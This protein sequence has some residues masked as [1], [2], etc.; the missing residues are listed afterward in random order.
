MDNK[1]MDS[2]AENCG[3]FATLNRKFGEVLNKFDLKNLSKHEINHIKQILVKY[4]LHP[5]ATIFVAKNFPQ[6]LPDLLTKAINIEEVQ[7][8]NE[9]HIRNC[10]ILSKLLDVHPDV[11]SFVIK[12]FEKNPSPFISL[13]NTQQP[14]KQ[15]TN[16][17][18]IVLNDKEIICMVYSFLKKMPDYFKRKWCWSEFIEK[19]ENNVDETVKWI[20]CNCLA[21]ITNMTEITL[22]K[23]IL[24]KLTETQANQCSIKYLTN[25]SL[26]KDITSITFN[27]F[28]DFITPKVTSLTNINGI[29]LPVIGEPIESVQKIVEVDS[30]NNNLKKIALGIVSNKRINLIGPVGSGKTALIEYLASKTG[31][32]LGESFIKIQL[33]DQSDSKML[34]GT[35]R[36]TDIPGE[37]I[38]QPGVLTQAVMDGSWLLLEDIDSASIDIASLLSGLLENGYL[39]VPG[40]RD[41]VPIKQ[42]FQLFVTQRLL[43]SVS[44]YQRIT[45]PSTVLLEKHLLNINIQPLSLEELEYIIK[46][47]HPTLKTISTRII[48]IFKYLNDNVNLNSTDRN[49]RC[50]TTR[51][52]FKWCSRAVVNFDV[53]SPTSGLKLL[54]DALDVFCY[55]YS[56]IDD[57]NKL[58]QSICSELGI[59]TEKVN[60]F[61]NQYK[62]NLNVSTKS[63]NCGRAKLKV[64]N[65]LTERKVN[66]CFTR[67]ASCLL[68]RIMCCISANE[69][70]LLVGETGTGKTSTVQY[71][72]RMLGQKLIVINMNQQ[73]DSSD[74]FGGFK[75][76]EIKFIIGPVKSEFENLFHS[77]YNANENE[78][79]LGHINHCFSKERYNDLVVLMKTCCKSALKK[80]ENGEQINTGAKRK[81]TKKNKK[82]N[83]NDDIKIKWDNFMKKIEKLEQQLKHKNALAFTFVEGSLVKAIENGYWVLLDEINLASVETLDCLSGLLE[84]KHSS[85]SLLERGDKKP[86]KRHDNFTLFA[87]MN[88]S[89]DV[90]KKNLPAGL[91]NRFTELFVDELT[92][93]KDLLMLVN[94]YLETLSTSTKTENIVKF[95]SKVRKEAQ[96]ILCDG[97]GHKP[98]FSLR[99]LCRA[100]MIGSKNPC[101]TVLRSLYEAFC[102]SFLTQLDLSSYKIVERMISKYIV[103]SENQLKSVIKQPIPKPISQRETYNFLQFEGYWISQGDLE[104]EVP[105][106]YILTPSVRKNLKD[107][108]RI[109]S[110]G[111]LPILLQGDTSVGKTSLIGYLAKSSGNKC[112]RINNHEHTDLQEYIGSYVADVSGKLV[113]REGVLVE[114][115]RNGHW[116]ILDELNLAPSDVLEALNRVLDDNRE[117]FIPET[118]QVVKAHHKFMLFATQNPPGTY[119]GRKMLSRAFRNRFVE[120]HF[121]EIPAV[122]LETILQQRCSLAPSYAKK[123]INVMKDLQTRRRGSAAFAGKYG[124]I[125]LRDLFRWGERYRLAEK[126]DKLYDWDQHLADEG[127]LVLAG[128]VRK[129]EE[130]LEIIAVLKKYLKRDVIPNNLFTLSDK[131]STVTKEILKKLYE[132]NEKYNNIVWTYNMRQMAVLVSKALQFYEPVL[133]VGETGCGKT[134]ICDVI[135]R[136]NN[137]KLMTI[138][139]HMHTESSDFIGGLRPVR[140]H[141]DDVNK[142]FEWIDGPL[143][144]AMK[145]GCLF[146]T[147]EISLADDSVLERLNSLLEPE[148]SLLL[149]EKGIDINNQANSELIIAH[150]DFHFIGTMNPGGDYGKKELSP[151]L[152]NR[153]TEIWS[154]PCSNRQDFINIINHNVKTNVLETYNIGFGELIMDFIDWFQKEDIGK[155][156][157]LTIRDV[158]TWV[159]FINACSNKISIKDLYLNGAYITMLDS[160]GSGVLNIENKDI[161]ANIKSKS[162]Q[163]LLNTLKKYNI[164]PDL[165][166]NVNINDDDQF[167]IG[168][169]SIQIGFAE[170]PETYFS[171]QAPTTFYNALRVVRG[172]QLNKPIL[173]EGSPGVG[174]TSLV[175]ALA[176]ATQNKLYRVNLSDQTDISD[177]FGADLPV[178]G[179]KSGQFSWRDGP[180]LQALKKGHWVLLDELNLASQSVLEGLNACLDHR[181]EIFIPELGKTFVVKEGT[182]FFG[183][184]NPIRQ[185]GSRRGLPKSFLNRFTQVYVESLT[186]NDYQ[187]ILKS[188][189]P[190]IEEILIETMVRFN[191]ELAKVLNRHLF[192]HLGGPWEYNLRDLTRWCEI[193]NN[194]FKETG[195][196]EPEKFINLIY[197]NRLRK[198]EDRNLMRELFQSFFKTNPNLEHGIVYVTFDKI[199]IGD[200]WMNREIF[201]FNLSEKDSNLLVLR[202]QMKNLRDLCYCV[203][204]NWLAILVGG[205]GSGKSSLVRTLAGLAGKTLLTLPVTSAM[206]TSDLLGGFEQTDYTRH[207]E[208]LFKQTESLLNTTIHS[209]LLSHEGF[210]S[211]K[212]LKAL[213]KCREIPGLAVEKHTMAEETKLFIKKIEYLMALWKEIENNRLPEKGEEK[214]R[215]LRKK[216]NQLLSCVN[217]EGGLNAGGKFEWVDSV[218]IKSLINGYWLLIDNVNLCSPAVLDR[219]NGLLEPNGVLTISERGIDPEGKMIEIKPHKDFRLFFTMNPKNGE[220]SRAMRNRGIELFLLNHDYIESQ[221]TLDIKSLIFSNGIENNFVINTLIEMHKY[222]SDLIVGEKPTTIDLLQSAFLISQQINRGINVNE[223]VTC[224]IMDIYYKMRS[225]YEFNINDAGN[226]IKIRINEIMLGY[227]K[228]DEFFNENCTLKI[229]DIN[230]NSNVAKIKQ[231]I[232]CFGNYLERNDKRFFV[233]NCYYLNHFYSMSTFNDLELRH[234][235]VKNCFKNNF[236]DI[237]YE[238]LK[239]MAN[240]LP[241]DDSW[242]SFKDHNNFYLMLYYLTSK[243]IVEQPPRKDLKVTLKFIQ[244]NKRKFSI[245]DTDNII[246]KKIVILLNEFDSFVLN[247]LKKNLIKIPNDNFMEFLSGVEWRKYIYPEILK[248]LTYNNE[249]D[250]NNFILLY[251]H[252]KWFAKY[253]VSKITEILP[254]E[255]SDELLT[256]VEKINSLLPNHFSNL[257]KIGKRYK[258]LIPA[259][260]PIINEKHLEIVLNFDQIDDIFNFYKTSNDKIKI[261]DYKLTS[262]NITEEPEELKYLKEK[263]KEIVLATDKSVYKKFDI[264]FLV[265]LDYFGLLNVYRRRNDYYQLENIDLITIPFNLRGVLKRYQESNDEKLLFEINSSITYYLLN[266]ICRNKLNENDNEINKQLSLYS[267][268][269]SSLLTKFLINE[270]SSIQVKLEEYKDSYNLYNKFMVILWS[271]FGDLSAKT[272]DFIVSDQKYILNSFESFLKD[273]SKSLRISFNQNDYKEMIDFCIN[274]ISTSYHKTDDELKILIQLLQCSLKSVI[275]L[276]DSFDATDKLGHLSDSFIY[277]NYL[278]ALLNSKLPPI[279]S[280]LKREIKRKYLLNEIEN[281]ECLE[282]SYKCQGEIYTNDEYPIIECFKKKQEDLKRKQVELEEYLAVRPSNLNYRSIFQVVQ[283]AFSTILSSKN[284]LEYCEKLN[285]SIKALRKSLETGEYLN[286]LEKGLVTTGVSSN[287]ERFCKVLGKNRATYPDV[288]EPLYS[289][290]LELLYGIKLKEDL[291]KKLYMKCSHQRKGLNLEKSLQNLV[292]FPI[293]NDE[294]TNF[295]QLTNLYLNENLLNFCSEKLFKYLKCGILEIYNYAIISSKFKVKNDNLAIYFEKLIKQFIGVWNKH[296]EMIE[297]ERNESQTLYKFKS[298]E[299]KTEEEIIQEEFDELFPSYHDDDFKEFQ[300]HSLDHIHKEKEVTIKEDVIKLDD[301]KYVYEL[302]KNFFDILTKTNWIESNNPEDNFDHVTPLIEKY[303][304]F[305]VLLDNCVNS[306]DY[307]LDQKLLGSLTVLINYAKNFGNSHHNKKNYNFYHDSNIEE[308]KKSLHI[309]K[310]LQIEINK[311]LNEWPEH[312]TLQKLNTIINRIYNFDV[313][314]SISRFLTGFEILLTECNEWEQNAHSGVSLQSSIT[315]VTDQII[316]WRK[317]ELNMWKNSLNIVYEKL[318]L[319]IGKWWCFIYNIIDQ[320]ETNNISEIEFIDAI[321]KF[322]T[323]SNIAE[324]QNRLGL[325]KSFN[326][327][328]VVIKKSRILQNILWNIYCYYSQFLNGVILKIKDLRNPIEQKLRGYVKIVRWKDISYWAVKDTLIKTHKIIH[329]HMKEYETVLQQPVHPFLTLSVEKNNVQGVW[330][331]PQKEIAQINY[332]IYI[333]SNQDDKNIN[334]YFSKSKLISH[335]IISS[336][337]YP[338]LIENMEEFIDEVLKSSIHLQNLEVDKTL[339]Q[340]KQKSQAKGI[341]Q[342]KRRGL[343]DLFKALSKMGLSYKK[344]I[345][346]GDLGDNLKRFKLNPIDL[347][348]LLKNKSQSLVDENILKSWSSS[349]IYYTKSLIR[350]DLLQNLLINPSKELGPQE[351]ERCKGYP[352]NLMNNILD[353]KEKLIDSANDITQL[354]T[355]LNYFKEF[356]ASKTFIKLEN[357]INLIESLKNAVIIIE[358][359]KIILN[360]C[361]EKDGLETN[362]PLLNDPKN[363]L[364]YKN[365][366]IWTKSFLLLNQILEEIEIICKN[367]PE[368]I[369]NDELNI[370]YFPMNNLNDLIIKVTNLADKLNELLNL[371]GDTSFSESL[372]WITSKVI[373]NKEELTP[374][375]SN[376]D[377]IDNKDLDLFKNRNEKL[378][379]K[380]LLSIQTLLKNLDVIDQPEN[381]EEILQTNHLNLLTTEGIFNSISLLNTKEIIKI[382]T[383]INKDLQQR[384]LFN[385]QDTLKKSLPIL[386]QFVLLQQFLFTQQVSTYRISSKINSILLNIFT[387]LIT[388]GF[389][390]PPEFSDEFSKEGSSQQSSGMGLGDGEGEKDVSDKIESEDQLEDAKPEGQEN[391]QENEDKDC[392]EEEGGIE[393]SEDFNSKLQDVEKK[394]DEENEDASDNDSDADEQMGETETGA[395]QLDKEIWGSDEEDEKDEQENGKESKDEKGNGGENLN[396]EEIGSKENESDEKRSNQPQDI[397][398]DKELNEDYDDEQIDPYHQNQQEPEEPEPMDLPDDFNLEEGEEKE[399]ETQEENPFDI[400]EMKDKFPPEIPDE[401]SEDIPEKS[402]EEKVDD[403][404]DQDDSDGAEENL[405]NSD[406]KD[407]EDK[408]ENENDIKENENESN[409]ENIPS[410]GLDQNSK[411]EENQQAMDV[412]DKENQS[413]DKIAT[414]ETKNNTNQESTETT[415]QEN[416]NDCEGQGQCQNDQ[417]EGGHQDTSVSQKLSNVNEQRNIENNKRMGE[418]DSNRSLGDT[419]LPVKKKLK[420][421]HADDKQDKQDDYNNEEDNKDSD[422]YQHIKESQKSKTQIFDAATKEQ[423]DEQKVHNDDKHEDK[424]DNLESTQNIPDDD[425]MEIDSEETNVNENQSENVNNKEDKSINKNNQHPEGEVLQEVDKVEVEGDVTQTM[426][427]PRGNETFFNQNLSDLSTKTANLRHDELLNLRQHIEEELSTWVQPPTNETAQKTWEEIS[428]VTSSLAHHLAEQLRLVLEPTQASRL[429]GDF[430]TGKRINM[431]KIIPYIASQFRK[432]KI[433]LR[434]T[435][436]AKRDY[437]IVLAID[438]SSSM[439]DNHSKELAFE[440]VALISRA[441]NLLESGE[442][443]I[444]SFGET[445]QILHKLSDPFTER[446]GGCLLQKFQFAEKKTYVGQMLNFATEMLNT[447][448]GKSSALNAKLIV[449]VSDGRGIFSEGESLVYSAIRNA[450]LSNVFTIFIIV[451]NPDNNSSIL[452]IRRAVFKSDNSIDVQSYMDSFPFPFYIVLRDIN[453]LPSVL[454]DALRQWFE[455]VSNID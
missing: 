343:A 413:S 263:S 45:T 20:F 110:I 174:K 392:K 94:S 355:Y 313:N 241:L 321:Q 65:N 353:Q 23:F 101:G 177:L 42:G 28:D 167:K 400:D 292:A 238:N 305:K 190:Q 403:D 26:E 455:M 40:Y 130:K 434:R 452:D 137:Q 360:T 307:N 311:Y 204:M 448:P 289:N 375:T 272:F 339:T 310:E 236:T 252:Y 248:T 172:M 225:E 243:F 128:K 425:E 37:F 296:Q 435:K 298:S 133:I 143:I 421:I 33:G 256:N 70:V 87:C 293:L 120:L 67:M 220:I 411:I 86:I 269:L 362:T 341:L 239:T 433:W 123:I 63:I 387:E 395:D 48:N 338:K 352:I 264:Q 246:I 73:S 210:S 124:F 161:I 396:E 391:N 44:G 442:L 55:S 309:L 385:F 151:A 69:P 312:P 4:L 165:K 351:I 408:N 402:E 78:K 156:F 354:K 326:C 316:T 152:R 13:H 196:F 131:T 227:N 35:Y 423:V 337:P 108:T 215:E 270:D 170:T 443:S 114:A 105:E 192:G 287:I 205:T 180:L 251:V 88:P 138:N 189:F 320:F 399:E 303:K 386:D 260:P 162:R 142:L 290:V 302:Q 235:F 245:N 266:S 346:E 426:T 155:Q 10:L 249:T 431:R 82:S 250:S 380:V 234:L 436:P 181:G 370:T 125:T 347:E 261:I 185:G 301:V 331:Q 389:C 240:K 115:M 427:V 154:E 405:E 22:R 46:T 410:E 141:T 207:L 201:N 191:I 441:L 146:L 359:Y 327:Q 144:E 318:N 61:F 34:L 5:D 285:N 90:G 328:C 12:Y 47:L 420:T 53:T 284:I 153:F 336:L 376:F 25:N 27:N 393:M 377:E 199:L 231:E 118:Q 97:L 379:T 163:F 334:K 159:N 262:K 278:K 217:N 233:V 394:G 132:N 149:A 176:N 344:G 58:A 57:R 388:K 9:N 295:I 439:A 446:T 268:I 333:S 275:D 51:D 237:F 95:Y 297:K 116:I 445:T 381:Y 432:D 335:K 171:F 232:S 60:Y 416:Q 274:T 430:K 226:K 276:N 322:L 454:S 418:S 91:R 202:G 444:L 415:E 283:H 166:T 365:D 102:L 409:A 214:I 340:S 398:L 31:R 372:K 158:L 369:Q 127:Y 29:Y 453:S 282:Y 7:L 308:I 145:E 99:S 89:T 404:K 211:R 134:T 93:E 66:F 229:G 117:L 106:N 85:I 188:Q 68:E 440:S 219:L 363:C 39:T 406:Q 15:R 438:D 109:V 212:L 21:I 187:I 332:D 79:F 299:N 273:F 81:H 111:Q 76:T 194:D 195:K 253:C 271:Y 173:L 103:G 244:N 160:I 92:D 54:Q 255:T 1:V 422:I 428:A 224:S 178:E 378:I 368:E 319:P 96:M 242:I 32:I 3:K 342:Q 14:K 304:L 77:F 306:I 100:L 315:N 216:G 449:V 330:D 182:K 424:D 447:S 107:L 397:P 59:I 325:L 104:V 213:E 361:P 179:G 267:P 122:E 208:D 230:L 18:L 186:L 36:C 198:E 150:R 384:N 357:L 374:I 147:D 113:F 206:D 317:L 323:Q 112:V 71:L 277:L 324:F 451:D 129:L 373:I 367:I 366:E 169:F 75:P 222:I 80:F 72:A 175:T 280:Q 286:A 41:Y 2:F 350:L 157:S 56:N 64:I 259:P 43:P 300:K 329:K 164:K 84:G 383:K 345:L 74:L 294:Q 349:E 136:I 62:P 200:T 17:E 358:E 364:C 19:Y 184:Q 437:Q 148:R 414:N 291:A 221:N 390:I 52:L 139:C 183:C 429:K 209:S 119:G 281:I 450:K 407:I 6:D 140:D 279:D 24:T 197:A 254:K 49:C 371:F 38:W 348:L 30:T 265:F 257:Q 168:P 135:A 401:I 98:H 11:E 223:A 218:L 417:N 203:K 121:N 288:I 412:D 83:L 382:I 8:N 314:S 193:I 16:K 126:S 50:I 258:K 228:E 356:S 419:N 247:V